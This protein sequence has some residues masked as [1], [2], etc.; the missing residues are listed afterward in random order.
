MNLSYQW[1]N[2]LSYAKT[3]NTKHDF[4]FLLGSEYI[5]SGLGR[6]MSASRR[7]YLFEDNVDTWTL[8]NGERENMDN[9]SSWNGRVAMFGIFGRLIMYLITDTWLRDYQARWI[10][11]FCKVRSLRNFPGTFRR[12]ANFK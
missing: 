1:T 3:I 12:M 2:T 9:T 6:S 4:N 10:F 5:N 11:T 7:N 8:A